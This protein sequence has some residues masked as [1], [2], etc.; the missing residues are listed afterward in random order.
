VFD[1]LLYVAAR[2]RDLQGGGKTG[3][4]FLDFASRLLRGSEGERKSVGLLRSEWLL[5]ALG[6]TKSAP[7]V[8]SGRRNVKP[9]Q[10]GEDWGWCYVDEIELGL[11]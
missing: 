2:R 9:F 8:E 3:E 4:K 10:P 11:A 7:G 6:V 1:V 5:D